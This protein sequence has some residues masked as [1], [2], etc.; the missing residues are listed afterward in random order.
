MGKWGA[1]LRGASGALR[2]TF[3]VAVVEFRVSFG[4]PEQAGLNSLIPILR[5]TV[6]EVVQSGVEIQ[7]VINAEEERYLVVLCM[8]DVTG[9][10]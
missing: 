4:S 8:G 1:T 7:D 3:I 5:Q 2:N 6:G 10:T 9:A